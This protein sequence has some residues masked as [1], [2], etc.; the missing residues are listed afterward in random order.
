MGGLATTHEIEMHKLTPTESSES[1]P[2]DRGLPR[3][4]LLTAAARVIAAPAVASVASAVLMNSL[5]APAVAQSGK[6]KVVAK[7]AHDSGIV[8]GAQSYGEYLSGRVAQLTDNEFEIQLYP[9]SQ[10]GSGSEL[11]QG[12]KQ[13]TLEFTIPTSV[14]AATIVAPELGVLGLPYLIRDSEQSARM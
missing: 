13:G 1:I 14:L 7:F 11:I 2:S 6:T 5:P 3:R 12:V 9:A 10:L 8:S 4:S